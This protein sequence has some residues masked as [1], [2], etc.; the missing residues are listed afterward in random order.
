MALVPIEEEASHPAAGVAGRA[1]VRLT[2]ERRQL[3]GVRTTP[4]ERRDLVV[5]VRAAGRVAYDPDLYG[6]VTE[7]LEAL[8][9]RDKTKESPW[10]DVRE[11]AE[12]LVR[13]SA[14]RLR[15][16]GLSDGQIG[17]LTPAS[18][19]PTNLL[20]GEKGGSVWVYAQIYDYEAGLVKPG[21]VME[22]TGTALGVRRVRGRVAAVDTILNPETRSLK[23]RAEVPNP[24]GLLKPE[25]YVDAVIHVPLGKQLAV[26]QGAILDTGTRQLAF[27]EKEP[28]LFEPREVELGREAEGFREVRSGLTEGETVVTSANFLLDSESALKAAV[29]A[30]AH[31][32]HSQ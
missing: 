12:A 20:L 32:G 28:G 31:A 14:L 19:D 3:I 6:A 13:S 2:P 27:V 18:P 11:R 9:T 1:A 21:Q 15:Q 22:I 4:V 25:M 7:R 10:P 23:V 24:A 16:M 30:P 8:R 29:S 26:P 17:G 5:L